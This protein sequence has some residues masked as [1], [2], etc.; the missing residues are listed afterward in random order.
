MRFGFTFQQEYQWPI[1]INSSNVV[2]SFFLCGAKESVPLDDSL[3][4][5]LEWL[6]MP[7]D[8]VGNCDQKRE[9]ED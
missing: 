5:L 7:G 9:G 2:I 6:V 3:G 4:L 1:F 8:G